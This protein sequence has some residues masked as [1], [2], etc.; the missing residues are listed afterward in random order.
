MDP[1]VRVINPINKYRVAAAQPYPATA[2]PAG[3]YP[4]YPNYRNYKMNQ[5]LSPVRFKN[6]FGLDNS[7]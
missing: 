7:R 2:Y 5:C 6:D 1:A 3:P 4:H